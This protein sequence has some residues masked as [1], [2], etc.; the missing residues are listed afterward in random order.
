MPCEPHWPLELRTAVDQR[1]D[2]W[3]ASLPSDA[4]AALIAA[5]PETVTP[6]FTTRAEELFFDLGLPP[7]ALQWWHT[8]AAADPSSIG[9]LRER[10]GRLL[11][12]S[13][14]RHGSQ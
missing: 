12:D 13:L 11:T 3:F 7:G 8:A 2:A 1:V 14:L 9:A 5:G 4:R 6:F 10:F